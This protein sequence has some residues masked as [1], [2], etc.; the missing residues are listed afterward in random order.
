MSLFSLRFLKNLV[1]CYLLVLLVIAPAAMAQPKSTKVTVMPAITD[2]DRYS[3]RM[4]NLALAHASTR[5]DIVPDADGGHR[6]QG[7]LCVQRRGRP[8]VHRPGGG[9]PGDLAE[10]GQGGDLH[11]Q[12]VGEPGGGCGD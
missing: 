1:P 12:A 10:Q 4:L 6:T 11:A 9:A 7:G 5:Y 2:I 8:E 3:V